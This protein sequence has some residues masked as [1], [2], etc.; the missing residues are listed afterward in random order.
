MS[1]ERILVVEDE[2]IIALELS[3]NLRD[4]GYEPLGP[5]RSGQEAVSEALALCP[6]AIL[7]DIILKG[8][9]DGIQAAEAILSKHLCPVIYV[10]AHSD[11][12]TLERAK[13]TEPFGYILKPIA[14]RELH[15][16]IEIA[17][18]RHRLEAQVRENREWFRT[19]LRSVDQA[20][21]T[22]ENE[23]VVSFLNPCA[24]KLLGWPEADALG[25]AVFEVF[26]VISEEPAHAA[27][28]PERVDRH[29]SVRTR[30]GK[31]KSIVYRAAPIVN[32]TPE[33]RGMVIIFRKTT[34]RKG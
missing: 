27:I 25:K 15:V 30:D 2:A 7:M 6:D 3:D 34:S 19:T 11:Q 13:V 29:V 22:L 21:I 17:L 10:T 24:E 4:I 16:A 20:I 31:R 23:G 5:C 18:C 12:S 1:H 32:G 33:V 26:N 9:M 8:P 14:V 28:L